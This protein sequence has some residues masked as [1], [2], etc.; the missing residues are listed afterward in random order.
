MTDKESGLKKSLNLIYV[1]IAA[2]GA[3]F[4]F[5]AYWDSVFYKYTGA[6]TFIAFALMALCILPIGFVYGELSSIFKQNGGELIYNTVGLNKHVGFFSSWLIM[7]AWISVPPAVVMGIMTWIS[8]QFKLNLDFKYIVILGI[9][10]LLIYFMLSL[11][12]VQF[13]IKAQGIMLFSNI[14]TTLI[15]SL[16]ILFSGHWSISNLTPLFNSK[17]I[18]QAGMPAWIIGMALLITPFFGF[19][20]VPE[21]VE[22]GDFPIKDT[23]KAIRGS[24][25][26]C[27]AIYVFYFFCIA[28]LGTSSQLLTADSANGFLA[29]VAMKNLLGWEIWPL[30]FGL[31]SVL[32][33]MGASLLGFWMATVRLLYAMGEQNYLPKAFTKVNKH[34]QPIL[35]NIFL[36]VISVVFIFLQNASNF[37]ES[38][39]NLMAFGCACAYALTMISAMR[40][41]GKHPEW[42]TYRLPGG[43]FTRLISLIIAL[44]IA[45]FTSLGQG[46]NSWLSF[47]VYLGVGIILWLYMV[48]VL[49][50]K[51]DVVVHTPDG[52]L[53]L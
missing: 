16:L 45:F 15:T 38:F 37:M 12:D 24:V 44:V 9:V 50:R 26:T 49:W 27:A 10:I 6:G 5:V 20:T 51:T 33:G 42:A 18:G 34:Q 2:T 46:L 25:I 21:M 36:L 23:G 41:H 22:E 47:L 40:I 28:G 3:I 14:A 29:I 4:T 7:A 52:P 53:N 8:Y 11:Q 43:Q 35:P 32:L 19:E 13:L 1:Y 48:L 17:L 39:F 31:A 30:I